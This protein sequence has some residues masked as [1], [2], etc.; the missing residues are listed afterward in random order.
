M[1]T[2]TWKDAIQS[3]LYIVD[4]SIE[5]KDR[6]GLLKDI[7]EVVSKFGVNILD[8]S[9]TPLSDSIKSLKLFSLAVSD[10]DQ[11]V[12]LIL[13]LNTIKNVVKVSKIN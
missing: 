5:L 6:V 4:L 12:S 13:K 7:V 2:E 1:L 3:D 8:V 9:L 11:L 10:Y